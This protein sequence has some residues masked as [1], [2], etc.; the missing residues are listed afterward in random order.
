MLM[1]KGET[2]NYIGI[3]LHRRSSQIHIYDDQTNSETT[4]RLNND[5]TL[6]ANFFAPFKNNCRVTVEATGNWYWLVD[7]LQDLGLEVLLANPLQTKAIAHA[8][9][10]NDKVDARILTHLLRTELLPT[11]WIPAKADRDIRDLLRIR[12]NLLG[13]RTQLKN[14]IR[15][16][17]AKFNITL[18]PTNIWCGA[19]RDSLL[20]TMQ[21]P[22]PG[23]TEPQLLP[24]VSQEA[25]KQYLQHIDHLSDQ[26]DYWEKI[27]DRQAGLSNDAQLLM[28][29]PGIGKLSALTIV[30]ETGPIA[31]FLGAKQ[32]T[33]Y[34]GLV[35]ITKSSADKQHHGHLCKQANLYL[36]RIFVEIALNALRSSKTDRRLI[37]YHQRMSKRK[38][39]G[40]AR[41]ALARKIA[42]IVYHMLREKIDYQ[43]A[44]T[45]NNMAGRAS[46]HT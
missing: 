4:Q 17:L 33:A 25:T 43:T 34:V 9:V 18:N 7:L 1:V 5:K 40:I 27:I 8:R 15:S 13:Y 28:T 38:G 26:I 39:M 3:D 45:K 41:I 16:I 29:F 12:L 31:R 24:S 20:Q 35:P 37:H 22:A 14:V 44:M 32:Y 30:Y 10:K 23:S 19:G 21:T 42:L 36:K 6:I 46:C 11:C 2:M